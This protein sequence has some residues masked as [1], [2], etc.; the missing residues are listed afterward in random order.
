MTGRISSSVGVWFQVFNMSLGTC[1]A[2]LRFWLSLVQQCCQIHCQQFYHRSCLSPKCKQ[3]W[4]DLHFTI[5][6]NLDVERSLEKIEMLDITMSKVEIPGW[7]LELPNCWPMLCP[8]PGTRWW[9]VL[10]QPR[11]CSFEDNDIDAY[12]CLV[13]VYIHLN[14]NRYSKMNS[15]NVNTE[16]FLNPKLLTTCL[17]KNPEPKTREK[18]GS[19]NSGSSLSERPENIPPWTAGCRCC[20]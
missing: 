13:Y 8:K 16:M 1:R 19:Q 9:Q 17:E 7:L 15:H 12:I 2:F 4:K 5:F 6:R 10:W 20:A 18:S 14:T 11:T 3:C